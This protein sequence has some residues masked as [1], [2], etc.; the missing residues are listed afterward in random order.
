MAS[1][2]DIKNKKSRI[3]HPSEYHFNKQ[4]ELAHIILEASEIGTWSWNI[5]TDEIFL[6]D[7]WFSIH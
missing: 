2:E 1:K 5:D 3:N 4:T 6:D 7:K